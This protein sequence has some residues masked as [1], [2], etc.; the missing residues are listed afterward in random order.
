MKPYQPATGYFWNPPGQKIGLNADLERHRKQEAE[1]Q[2][3]IDQAEKDLLADPKDKMAQAAL[4]VYRH[5][6]A[7]LQQSKAEVV[8]KIGRNK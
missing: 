2:A 6:L 1:L 5:S 8:N 3:R 7:L 4:R